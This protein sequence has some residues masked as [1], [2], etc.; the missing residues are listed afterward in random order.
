MG[1]RKRDRF[2]VFID[3]LTLVQKNN[4]LGTRVSTLC[5]K[6][7]ASYNMALEYTG[8]FIRN[9]LLEVRQEGSN[10]KRLFI[11]DRG[12]E[13]LGLMSKIGGYLNK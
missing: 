10:G 11:T 2:Q 5:L 6:T 7:N 12:N 8:L 1:K 9:G 4:H 3:M 13:L